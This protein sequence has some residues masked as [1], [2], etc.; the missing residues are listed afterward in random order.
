LLRRTQTDIHMSGWARRQAPTDFG[1]AA[2]REPW[3]DPAE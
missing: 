2:L 1:F 3:G